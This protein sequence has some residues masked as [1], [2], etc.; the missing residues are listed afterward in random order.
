MVGVQL[1]HGTWHMTEE[2]GL[3]KRGRVGPCGRAALKD[4][5]RVWVGHMEGQQ[6]RG[7]ACTA[8]DQA[9]SGGAVGTTHNTTEIYN[10]DRGQPAAAL[11]GVA[12]QG[13]AAARSPQ[14]PRRPALLLLS[15]GLSSIPWGLGPGVLV[16][17]PHTFA[18]AIKCQMSN[19][20]S[21]WSSAGHMSSKSKEHTQHPT[22]NNSAGPSVGSLAPPRATPRLGGVYVSC[23]YRQHLHLPCSFVLALRE[24]GLRLGVKAQLPLRASSRGVLP[25]PGA[26]QAG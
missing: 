12:A 7:T 15:G 1:V 20:I 13:S 14:S 3:R 11:S 2:C 8:V 5:A 23:Q 19:V 6:V 24:L 17:P 22:R 21:G 10:Q 18:S 25:G 16:G 9:P 4:T 26:L